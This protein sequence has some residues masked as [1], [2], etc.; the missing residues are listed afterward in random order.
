VDTLKT[1]GGVLK[2]TLEIK[3]LKV[4]GLFIMTSVSGISQEKVGFVWSVKLQTHL[5]FDTTNYI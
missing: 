5:P 1:C 4:Q 3:G 2:Q